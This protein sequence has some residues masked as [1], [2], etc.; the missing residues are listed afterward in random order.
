[1]IG[2]MVGA[3]LQS[4]TFVTGIKALL[5][6]VAGLYLLAFVMRPGTLGQK[7]RGPALLDTRA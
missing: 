4:A 3:V 2:S 6:L 5:L 7:R 1:M